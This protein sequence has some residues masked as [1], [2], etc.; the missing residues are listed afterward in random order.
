MRTG[1]CSCNN[2]LM[3]A[4]IYDSSKIPTMVSS[5]HWP[6]YSFTISAALTK[7]QVQYE[8]THKQFQVNVYYASNGC[9]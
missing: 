5:F 4:F 6:E 8:I 3:W 2:K 7:H 9:G 1:R